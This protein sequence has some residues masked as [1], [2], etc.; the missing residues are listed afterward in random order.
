[1]KALF[2]RVLAIA[3]G[4]VAIDQLT[5]VFARAGLALCTARGAIGCDRVRLGGAELLRVR[6]A[7][8]AFGFQQD[9]W[10]WVPIAALGLALVMLYA[11]GSTRGYA[12]AVAAGL[13]LGGA[14]S[15]L[16]DR[17]FQAGVTDFIYLGAGPVFNLADV[18][19]AIG[20]VQGTWSLAK[21]SGTARSPSANEGRCLT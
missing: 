11:R 21:A 16:A 2:G 19:L 15:N 7:G 1:M 17:L 9:L 3:T 20:T 18:A 4:I 10:I 5:K 14:V 8:S 6:N 13:Q 12:I